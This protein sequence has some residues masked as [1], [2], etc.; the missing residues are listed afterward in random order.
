V[1]GCLYAGFV[2]GAA[3]CSGRRVPAGEADG[4]AGSPRAI[5]GGGRSSAGR[6]GVAAYS[7][8]LPGRQSSYLPAL[9]EPAGSP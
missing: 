9:I 6:G 5:G 7:L 2:T 3:H 4:W 1:R 8:H